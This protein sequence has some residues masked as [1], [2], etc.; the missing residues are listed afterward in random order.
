[1]QRVDAIQNGTVDTSTELSEERVVSIAREAAIILGGALMVI[2]S[3]EPW[4]HGALRGP[5]IELYRNGLQLGFDHSFSFAGVISLIVGFFAMLSG[6]LYLAQR[7]IPRVLDVPPIVLG[8]IGVGVGM[9]GLGNAS[10]Y[11]KAML[12]GYPELFSA[13]A[14]YGVWLVVIGGTLVLVAGVTDWARYS[15]ESRPI[16]APVAAVVLV[17][18]SAFALAPK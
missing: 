17:G 12:K 13:G 4:T 3:Y 1:L 8:L 18:L 7:Q 16:L 2:G 15:F 6:A 14:S 9:F 11:T 10:S 5:G